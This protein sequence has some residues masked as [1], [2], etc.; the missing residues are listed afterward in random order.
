MIEQ[1]YNKIIFMFY[2]EHSGSKYPLITDYGSK[3][4]SR[5]EVHAINHRWLRLSAGVLA[6]NGRLIELASGLHVVFKRK[7]ASAMASKV[8]G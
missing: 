7:E 1:G 2:S 5:T 4:E 3:N 6:R 8:L